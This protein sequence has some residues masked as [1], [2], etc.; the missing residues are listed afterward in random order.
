MIAGLLIFR[1]TRF[2]SPACG[3]GRRT[4][5]VRREGVIKSC[6][7][8]LTNSPPQPSPAT[9]RGSTPF[10]R[11]QFVRLCHHSDS[12]DRLHLDQKWFSDQPVHHQ[13]RVGRIFSVRK[14]LWEFAQAERH[15]LWNVLGVNQIGREL[16]DVRPGGPGGFERCLDVADSIPAMNRNSLPFTRVTWLYCP[17]GGPSS[18]AL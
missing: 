16:N 13:Q 18:S 7:A 17:M 1:Q 3:G 6:A 14:H 4:P 2:T 5:R 11:R 15:E 10:S 12:R 8:F 9:G